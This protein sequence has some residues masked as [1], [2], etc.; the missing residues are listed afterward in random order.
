MSVYVFWGI[1]IPESDYLD[2]IERNYSKQIIAESDP[3]RAVN[4]PAM[5]EAFA[6]RAVRGARAG[7]GGRRW[8]GSRKAS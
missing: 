3:S 5:V 6:R 1:K 8:P 7:G 4:M 2:F